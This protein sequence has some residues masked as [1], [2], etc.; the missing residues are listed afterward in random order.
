MEAKVK[1]PKSSP[2]SER[3]QD[4]HLRNVVAIRELDT[5]EL[6]RVVGGTP[7]TPHP[8]GADDET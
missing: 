4:L 3:P 6:A 1:A 5:A 2:A 8:G 7:N